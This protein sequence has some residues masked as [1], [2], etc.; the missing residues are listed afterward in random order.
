MRHTLLILTL[1]AAVGSARAADP[2]EGERLFARS[3][4]PVLAAKCLP[5]HGEDPKKVKG[6]LDLSSADAARKGGDGG[7]AFVPGKPAESPLYRAVTRTDPDLV[8]PPKENDKLSAAEVEAVRKWVELGAPWPATAR[9]KELAAADGV[10]VKTSGGLSADWTDRA[11]KP[12]DLWAY[13][14]LKRPP[15]PGPGKPVDAFVSAKLTALGLT[16]APAADKRTL[17]RRVTFDLT[18]L[19]PTPEEVDAF[20]N[21]GS[22]EAYSRVVERLLASPH[23]GEQMAR[24]WLDVTR[25]A[26]SAGF[27]ND[28][29][30]GNA[31]RYR[32]YVV[33]SFNADKPYD[34]FVK[35]QVAGD[36]ID[37]TDPEYLVAVGFLRMGAWELTGMEVAKV[38]R[39]RFLDDVTD[40]VGQVFL[41]H[42]LQ[43]AR[44]HDHKFDPVPT[45][46]YYRLQACFA[47][48][49]PTE[50]PAAFLPGETTAGFG[51]RK[52]L[53]ARKARLDAEL[54]RI[55]AA[56][57]DGKRKWAAANPD[58]KGEKPPRHEFLS[59]AD[60]GLERIARKGLER[61]KWEADRYEPVALSVYAGRTPQLRA[62]LTP[63]RPPADRTAGELEESAI[64]A[65]GDPFSPKQPV[66]PGVLSAVSEL[67]VPE[68][69][70]GRRKALAE[71]I[72]SPSNPLTARVMAN[73]VWQW[74]FGRG[75]AGTP[76]NFGATGKKPTHPELLDWLASEL[77]E[78]GWS[79]KHLHR[80]ILLSETY[81][82]AS[83]PDSTGYAAFPPRRLTAEELRDAM[84][85]ASGELNRSVGGIPA[86][87]E[88]S[89]DVALQPRQVMGTFA[90]AWEPSPTPEQRHRRSLY[91][92]RLRGLRDPFFEVFN[93]PGPDNPCEARE[94][95]TVSP[96]VFALFNGDSPR[97][98]ALAFAARL[99]KETQSADEAVT[100]ALRLAFG[101]PPTDAER[102][103]CRK[104][105]ERMTERHR[106]LTV[107]K[108]KRPREVVREAVEEN[109]GEKFRF[110][111]VLEAAGDF[112]PDL[113]PA[114]VSAEVRGLMEVCLV[115]FNTN[116]F[117]YLD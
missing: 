46:D 115:L 7:A 71:W 52:Y 30:R 93:Q 83:R 84:L 74:H 94:T 51:E 26:D 70:D 9:V 95:S 66:T 110:T 59:S 63:F 99:L 27:A 34:R 76:N 16:P 82:R 113:H 37:P 65:G 49:Q 1:L 98:R 45:R 86:R 62:I 50:R 56:E 77:I 42:M 15:V 117:A 40:T 31:W 102:D 104:H 13:Q 61:L 97:G 25:Y 55:Q 6:G 57:A 75:L 2:A 32:D 92:L 36:E 17:I 60:L 103:A 24:H 53:D 79:V 73:R 67:K 22:P 21:D 41:G 87:P 18:G 10:R 43:C 105:W 78:R 96:Q 69:V 109:T 47:T 3:V 58:K 38:A 81:R 29:D 11:Y 90:P 68:T 28:Y 19:P 80:V 89:P 14:P 101:R 39:Q 33:R 91:V 64:L 108:P 54:K 23:Y 106:G 107:E 111:E 48:T 85:A 5:C 35:E 88:L 116:E 100:R 4:W 44:C 114:D 20:L 112:V 12:D 8:M 72:V